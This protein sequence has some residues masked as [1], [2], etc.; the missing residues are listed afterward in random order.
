MGNVGAPSRLA[1]TARGDTM[2]VASRVQGLTRR[3]GTDILATGD[4]RR[5]AAEEF[6]WREVD[7]V[8]VKGRRKAVEM[9]ELL[10]RTGE[11][12]EQTLDWAGRYQGALAF[13]YARDFTKARELL[14]GLDKERPGDASVQLLMKRCHDYIET[15]PADDWDGIAR[16]QYK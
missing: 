2:N 11:V 14:E 12:D 7:L 16:M 1:Y 15:P 3:Y 4:I 13:F 9:F 6:A 8:A 10:G 5:G